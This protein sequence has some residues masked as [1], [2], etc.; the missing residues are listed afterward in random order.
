MDDAVLSVCLAIPLTTSFHSQ[1]IIV[2]YR[3]IM[4]FG[5]HVT[6][7]GY[8]GNKEKLNNKELVLECLN[9]L[10]ELLGMSKLADP[11]VYFAEGND[12]KDPGGWTG[13]VVIKESH[14][15]IHTFPERGFISAD[16]YT[17]KNGMDTEFIFNYFKTKFQLEELETNFIKRG[18]HYPQNNI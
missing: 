17:C 10:P 7:D 13:I 3:H 9:E 2:Q 5:E 6:I 18:T 12:L 16:V 14:I 11:T 1:N 8:G 15:S 4:H